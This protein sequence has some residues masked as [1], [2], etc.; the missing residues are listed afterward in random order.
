MNKN[1]IP[2]WIT[3]LLLIALVL[4]IIPKESWT[5][6]EP[7]TI[8]YTEDA[9]DNGYWRGVND[10]LI[11]VQENNY[12]RKDTSIS[13]HIEELLEKNELRRIEYL[14]KHKNK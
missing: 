10:M 3:G 8:D 4:L 1:N 6:E 12:I 9:F 13:I 11:Y 5:K 2:W 14:K 7:I